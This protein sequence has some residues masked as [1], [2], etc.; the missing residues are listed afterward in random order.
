MQ[1]VAFGTKVLKLDT[2]GSIIPAVIR[3]MIPSRI[4]EQYS[5]YCKEQNFEPAGQ[6]SLYRIIEVCGASM[7]KSLQGLQ[8]TTAEGTE[9]IDNVTDVLK[10]LG[11]HGSEATWVKD[12]EQKIKEA[13]GYLKTEFKSHVGRDETCADHCLAPALGDTSDSNLQSICQHKH[14]TE[15]EQCES[16]ETVLKEI[17]SEINLVEMLEE[18][19]LWLNHDFKLCLVSIQDW[20]AHLLCTVKQEEGKQIALEHV[21]SASCLF[22][23]D[24]A[25][26][27]L[28]QRYQE[29]MSDFFGKRGRSWHVSAVITKHTEKFQVKCFVHLFDD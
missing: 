26:K 15:C 22:V 20:K 14:E 17:E 24:W 12:A 23:M 21:D 8:N 29:R 1:D 9:A 6:R 5:A 19:S 4:I 27:Y 7:Q 2:G 13:K 18:H 28:R 11:D 10:T 25:M 3:I 16:L